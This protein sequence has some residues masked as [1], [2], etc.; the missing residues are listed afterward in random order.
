MNCG[1]PFL[2]YSLKIGSGIPVIM[3]DVVLV[4]I[5]IGNA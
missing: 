4:V 1:I 2:N 5:V 3:F